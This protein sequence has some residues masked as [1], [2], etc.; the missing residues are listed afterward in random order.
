VRMFRWGPWPS[1][2]EQLRARVNRIHNAERPAREARLAAEEGDRIERRALLRAT[3]AGRLPTHL[4]DGS[5]DPKLRR[6]ISEAVVRI[7]EQ[8][9]DTVKGLL[10]QLAAVTGEAAAK[11]PVAYSEKERKRIAAAIEAANGQARGEMAKVTR[12]LL[13]D[14]R[15]RSAEG[16]ALTPAELSEATLLVQEWS[17]R[18]RQERRSL[19]ADAAAALEVGAVSKARVLHRASVALRASSDDVGRG[20][21]QRDP[22]RLAAERDLGSVAGVSDALER[23]ITRELADHGMGGTRTSILAEVGDFM[24]RQEAAARLATG[25]GAPEA[26]ADGTPTPPSR[27]G[28]DFRG[29]PVPVSRHAALDDAQAAGDHRGAIAAAADLLADR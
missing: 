16:T 4:E 13:Q 25:A 20:L 3:L 12:P 24:A 10:G 26:D 22:I 11:Y 7:S 6:A 21:D 2:A 14:A 17:G 5:M 29:Q 1:R 27:S 23:A 28:A 19:A 15:R 18:T 9:A 8:R